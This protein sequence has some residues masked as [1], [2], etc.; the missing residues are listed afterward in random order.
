MPTIAEIQTIPFRLPMTGSL[1]WGKASHFDELE[2][3]LVRL[4]TDTGLVGL[5]IFL[6]FS[7]RLAKA[8]LAR[9]DPATIDPSPAGRPEKEEVWHL[10]LGLFAALTAWYVHG[11]FDYF[12]EFTPTYVAFWLLVALL[13]GAPRRRRDGIANRL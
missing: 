10:T 7:W 12:Y 4:V 11:F 5:L 2:H 3:V 13:V 9:L 1:S 8:G 6:W